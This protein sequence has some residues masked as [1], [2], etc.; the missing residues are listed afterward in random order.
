MVML[1]SVD[2]VMTPP[3]QLT[4]TVK[5]LLKV[6]GG[7]AN[8]NSTLS[9]AVAPK[10]TG[11]AQVTVISVDAFSAI[12]MVA[13]PSPAIDTE[14]LPAIFS[15]LLPFKV[16]EFTEAP[17]YRLTLRKPPRLLNCS[18]SSAP[19]EIIVLAPGPKDFSAYACSAGRV[20]LSPAPPIEVPEL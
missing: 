13:L 18:L 12:A 1:L 15:P 20:T 14:A 9:S 2:F 19:R 3:S 4:V 17:P 5:P 10:A 6:V 11:S 8:Q 16:T 7:T